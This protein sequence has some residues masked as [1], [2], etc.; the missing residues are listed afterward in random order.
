MEYE[1][2]NVILSCDFDSNF[3]FYKS[4]YIKDKK[5][6]YEIEGEGEGEG[7]EEN[8]ETLNNL[9]ENL[10]LLNNEYN[11]INNLSKLSQSIY[12]QRYYKFKSNESNINLKESFKFLYRYLS[13]NCMKRLSAKRD[14]WI[15]NNIKYMFKDVKTIEISKKFLN[16]IIN[17]KQECIHDDINKMKD[18]FSKYFKKQNIIF[19]Q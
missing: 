7:E 5:P 16:G 10:R 17:N 2:K 19:V 6:F 1:I 15:D 4:M 12:N 18:L 9:K 14:I 8:N 13:L 3:K 11:D